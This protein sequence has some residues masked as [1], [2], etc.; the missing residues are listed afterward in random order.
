MD[1]LLAF[2]GILC[3]KVKKESVK[4]GKGVRADLYG[5]LCFGDPSGF[6]VVAVG[7]DSIEWWWYSVIR[8][9]GS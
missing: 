8:V 4:I 3:L 1:K 7:L 5:F 2:L 9:I 6:C